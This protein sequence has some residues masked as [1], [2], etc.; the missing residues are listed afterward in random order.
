MRFSARSR[1]SIVFSLVAF[2]TIIGGLLAAVAL[3][4][5]INHAHAANTQVLNCARTALCTEV[6]DPEEVF[7]EGSYVGHDEPSTLFY[8]NKPGSGNNMRYELTLPSDPPAPGGVP[9]S[10]AESFNFQLHPAF[11]FGMA[12]CDTQS[13]PEQV[14][15]CTPDSDSNIVDPAVSPNHPGTAF[16]EL[17]FYPPGWVKWPGGF[18]GAGGTSCDATK[19]CIALNID[20]LS[21]DPVKGTTLNTTCATHITGGLEY[22]NFAFITKNGQSQGPAN[23]VQATAT[24][25]FTP[26][27]AKDLFMNSGD[28][29]VVTL[30]DTKHGLR[31][32]IQ[33][34]TNSQSGFMVASAANGFGQVK[35]APDPSTECT[36]IPYDFHPMYSTSSEQTR[37]IWAAHSYNIAF[38]DEIGH[39]DYCNGATIA[40]SPGGVSC[41]SG[42]T[43]GMSGDTEPTN[44]DDNFCFPAS[45]SSLVQLQGCTDTNTGFDGVPYQT[46]WPDGNTSL[47]PTPILFTSPLTGPAYNTNYKRMA[48]EADLPRIEFSTCN[49]TTG[50]GCTL[51]PTTDDGAPANFYPFYSITGKGNQ[52]QGGECNWQ[53]GNDTPATTNDFGKNNQYG[54]LL[55][56]TYLAFGGGGATLQRFN[57]FRQVLDKNPCK[58][59]EN[60]NN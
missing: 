12:M 21:E 10:P 16:M 2:V 17:Q 35:Y 34:L 28:E 36:N 57:D 33:D 18:F 7:G 4:G 51:I 41:P 32:D 45:Q 3:R 40:Q 25:T 29:L 56:L 58:L 59:H 15:T 47:H 13:Y 1:V 31:T 42:N 53:I 20:S 22:I 52:G 50:A 19:W 44:G 38:S 5:T 24:G 55:Q 14:S 46:A 60:N 27:P 6:A 43:E 49:R 11:W 48:F 37:V 23:P 54:S 9:T 26:D 8:S 30:H 39:F